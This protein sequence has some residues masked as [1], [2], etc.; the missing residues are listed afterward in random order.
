MPFVS[1]IL[2]SSGS[3]AWSVALWFVSISK[4]GNSPTVIE[5]IKT[6][7]SAILTDCIGVKNATL[8]APFLFAPLSA[9]S[10]SHRRRGKR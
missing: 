3:S 5:Q 4:D 1:L 9:S 7:Q 6:A 8:A 10:G 2:H